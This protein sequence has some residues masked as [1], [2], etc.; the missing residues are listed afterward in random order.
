MQGPPPPYTPHGASSGGGIPLEINGP[1]SVSGGEISPAPLT[2]PSPSGPESLSDEDEYDL[3]DVTFEEVEAAEAYATMSNTR[4]S[5]I[6]ARNE[7]P[8]SVE[9]THSIS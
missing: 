8:S 1:L 6:S 5:S 9:S 7:Q 3:G 2:S 4:M